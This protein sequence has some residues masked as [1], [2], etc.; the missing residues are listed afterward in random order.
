MPCM[1]VQRTF[2]HER[3]LLLWFVQG[4]YGFKRL[5]HASKG[6]YNGD[7]IAMLRRINADVDERE[8]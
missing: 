1:T 4:S 2:G 6:M 8:R 5:R 3:I 7:I